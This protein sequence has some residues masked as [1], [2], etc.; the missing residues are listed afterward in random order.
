MQLWSPPLSDSHPGVSTTGMETAATYLTPAEPVC[1]AIAGL[2][3]G[4]ISPDGWILL[5]LVALP[6]AG[7]VV[8]AW[9]ALRNTAPGERPPIIH[10][11]AHLLRPW[12]STRP[13]R[14]QRPWVGSPS[15]TVWAERPD[16][17]TSGCPSS[18][19][20]AAP[21]PGCLGVAGG[22]PGPA[23]QAAREQS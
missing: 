17:C 9:L 13:D 15:S 1:D 8:I 10:A 2:G 18:D 14:A 6:I 12:G 16:C 19:P 22:T 23:H 3:S 7:K 5:A 21:R 20:A 11:L 4:W